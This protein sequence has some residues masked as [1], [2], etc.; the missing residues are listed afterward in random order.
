MSPAEHLIL[1][2]TLTAAAASMLLL[3]VLRDAELRIAAALGCCS[4]GIVGSILVDLAL[5]GAR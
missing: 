1:A 3:V 5:H 4:I 2:P